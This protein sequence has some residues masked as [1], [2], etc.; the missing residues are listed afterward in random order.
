MRFNH[1]SV[2]SLYYVKLSMGINIVTK[3]NYSV[4]IKICI[5]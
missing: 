3:N 4:I 5:Q 1:A 2:R